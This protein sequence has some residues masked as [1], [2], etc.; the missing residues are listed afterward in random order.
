MRFQANLMG[1]CLIFSIIFPVFPLKLE[2]AGS[3]CLLND[4][5][6]GTHNGGGRKSSSD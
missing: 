3:A 5:L 2:G 4:L 6:G 1:Y